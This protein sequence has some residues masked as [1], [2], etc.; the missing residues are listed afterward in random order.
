MHARQQRRPSP[1][2]ILGP[3][4]ADGEGRRFPRLRAGP[5]PGQCLRE[6]P[7]QLSG[8]TTRAQ[9]RVETCPHQPAPGQSA[10]TGDRVAPD[11]G[12]TA[13]PDRRAQGASA[14]HRSSSL[15]SAAAIATIP[16][17]GAPRVRLTRGPPPGNGRAPA[18]NGAAISA[19]TDPV[20][21][22]RSRPDRP[23]PERRR[24]APDLRRGTRSPRRAG[25]DRRP[26]RGRQ[27]LSCHRRTG[28]RHPRHPGRRFRGPHD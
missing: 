8:T 21:R 15:S 1:R 16:V 27:D 18:G 23:E 5:R 9:P 26:P 22:R 2:I 14:M 13:S 17:P 24:G 28:Q 4:P 19:E 6:Q 10:G 3:G 7:P 20:P 12:D 11:P 25:A